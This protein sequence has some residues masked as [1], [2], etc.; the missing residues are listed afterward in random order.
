MPRRRTFAGR[1]TTRSRTGVLCSGGPEARPS[2][3]SA[4]T[5]KRPSVRSP[6]SE[7]RAFSVVLEL[8]PN[9]TSAMAAGS[10]EPAT[11]V[12]QERALDA[13]PR[14]ARPGRGARALHDERHLGPHEHPGGSMHAQ[15]QLGQAERGAHEQRGEDHRN[16]QREQQVDL[17]VRDVD[18]EGARHERD[19]E[20]PAPLAR[21]G[22]VQAQ[23]PP[24]PARRRL[25]ERLRDGPARA[26]RRDED[27]VQALP[28]DRAQPRQPRRCDAHVGTRTVETMRVTTP[29]PSPPP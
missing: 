16:E 26:R 2:G 11:E 19:H 6:R 22:P 1:G 13:E 12:R 14:G 27:V 3:T 15:R 8:A 10:R 5:R 29:A 4:L 24:S 20:E 18:R 9:P 17:G 7:K 25:A 21:E 28:V 23:Q